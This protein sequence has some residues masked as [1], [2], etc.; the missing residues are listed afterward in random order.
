MFRMFF[1]QLQ[2]VLQP[3]K[4]LFSNI[5]NFMS[6]ISAVIMLC[7][8][9]RYNSVIYINRYFL[10]V[11]Q[12]GWLFQAVGQANSAPHV[13]HSGPFSSHSRNTRE[14]VKPHTFPMTKTESSRAGI[15][16]TCSIWRYHK[17]TQQRVWI[18]DLITGKR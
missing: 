4:P 14:Q 5:G 16:T 7:N 2:F 11:G 6:H 3:S 17:V 1:V 15:Y 12:L 8:K 10:S 13:S 9:Q 18:N